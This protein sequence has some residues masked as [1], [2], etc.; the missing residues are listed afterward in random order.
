MLVLKSNL[1]NSENNLAGKPTRLFRFS[2]V[3]FIIY[4]CAIKCVILMKKLTF[5]YRELFK[6]STVQI[7]KARFTG[8]IQ[9]QSQSKMKKKNVMKIVR[10]VYAPFCFSRYSY[11]MISLNTE[12]LWIVLFMVKQIK[13]EGHALVLCHYSASLPR[14]S[15]LKWHVSLRYGCNRDIILLRVPLGQALRIAFE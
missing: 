11:Y 12:Y 3:I 8:L 7:S 1:Q 14:S 5:T 15:K 10:Y 2:F 4:A 9:T 6:I 13:N